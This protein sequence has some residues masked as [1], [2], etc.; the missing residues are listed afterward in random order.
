MILNF[1]NVQNNDVCIL[2][3]CD[4]SLICFGL[5]GGRSTLTKL[6]WPNLKSLSNVT[7]RNTCLNA[8]IAYITKGFIFYMRVKFFKLFPLQSTNLSKSDN[9]I[10]SCHITSI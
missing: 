1:I 2:L 8:L 10:I 7:I 5:L 9:I 4:F 6:E 3:M